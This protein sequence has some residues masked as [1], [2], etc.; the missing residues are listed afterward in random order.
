[1]NF[2]RTSLEAQFLL[3]TEAELRR[4]L[5]DFVD[6]SKRFGLPVPLLT[7]L[8]RTVEEN[9]AAGGVPTSLHL[10]ELDANR[11]PVSRAGD[12]S[13]RPYRGSQVGLAE[14]WLRGEIAMRGGLKRW[15][16][17]KHAVPGGAPH[18]HIGRRRV[19]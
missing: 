1:M 5:L 4:F 6:A 14:T 3:Q 19:P 7:C 10:W 18:F 17:L 12:V 9:E 8:G 11:N 15:E 16:F 13:L 2:K